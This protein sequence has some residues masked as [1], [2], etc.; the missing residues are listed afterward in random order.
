M[1]AHG[2]PFFRGLVFKAVGVERHLG[3]I[4]QKSISDIRI[5]TNQCDTSG[6]AS[7]IVGINFKDF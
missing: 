4:I 1:L 2:L 6:H 7:Q 5:E 3:A